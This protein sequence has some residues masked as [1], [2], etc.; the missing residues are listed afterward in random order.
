MDHIIGHKAGLKRYKNIEITP[1]IL[2]DHQGLRLIFNNSIN[3]RKTTFT[4][5]MNNTLFNDT[6][7]K[8]EIRKEMKD[9]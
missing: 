9:F 3:S 4:W 2:S 6:L 5:K 8:E 7:D 1:C